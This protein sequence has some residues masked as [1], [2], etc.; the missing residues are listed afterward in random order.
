[1]V[2]LWL[3]V[4]PARLAAA[5]EAMA[6]HPEVGYACATTGPHNLFASVLCRDVGA[7][8][9]Y[10]TTRVAAL[11]GVRAMESAPRIRHLKGPGPL[12]SGAPGRR[13]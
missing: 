7:V 5:G 8:Y 12:F 9:R 1:M 2:A 3:S 11:P 4:E 6:A 13:R 10:L